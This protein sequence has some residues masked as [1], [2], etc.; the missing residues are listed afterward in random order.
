MLLFALAAASADVMAA[1]PKAR[2]SANARRASGSARAAAK[3]NAKARAA[4]KNP[5]ASKNPA[6]LRKAGNASAPTASASAGKGGLKLALPPDN[7]GETSA[8]ETELRMELSNAGSTKLGIAS[9]MYN[10]YCLVRE[11]Q[12]DMLELR[13]GKNKASREVVMKQACLKRWVR[14]SDGVLCEG[15]SGNIYSELTLKKNIGEDDARV[16]AAAMAKI[17]GS[18]NNYRVFKKNAAEG[19]VQFSLPPTGQERVWYDSDCVAKKNEACKSP[20]DYFSSALADDGQ[21]YYN[22]CLNAWL[23][24]KDSAS[25][26]K[27]CE[28]G[29]L[30]QE[31]G[32]CPK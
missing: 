16:V 7:A 4:T 30:D 26:E 6:I 22:R 25:C 29:A 21:L 20:V 3:G 11:A 19:A 8:D 12:C 1:K 28:A 14:T 9:K 5:P 15:E 32:A 10:V 13:G 31:T 2:R 17:K 27:K 24:S 18:D 23:S